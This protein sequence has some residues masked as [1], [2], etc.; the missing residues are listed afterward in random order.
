MNSGTLLLCRAFISRPVFPSVRGCAKTVGPEKGKHMSELGA[1]TMSQDFLDFPGND[2]GLWTAAETKGRLLHGMYVRVCVCVCVGVHP[3][4]GCTPI[5]EV[6][7]Q[8]HRRMQ[9]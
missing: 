8:C 9:R 2:S 7:F 5:V 3:A 4:W 6:A 1:R